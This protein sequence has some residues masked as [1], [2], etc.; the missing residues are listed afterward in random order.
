VYMLCNYIY[1][2][3]YL[4]RSIGFDCDIESLDA[5]VS[6]S[7]EHE[8]GKS[9]YVENRF[10]ILQS[11]KPSPKS[12]KLIQL[13]DHSSTTFK[14]ILDTPSQYIHWRDYP[15]CLEGVELRCDRDEK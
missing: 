1:R 15:P 9:D 12:L 3:I 2:Y 6:L 5:L 14:T 7:E 11:I 4:N 8:T 13:P 10:S